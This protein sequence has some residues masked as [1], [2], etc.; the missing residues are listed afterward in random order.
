MHTY[1]KPQLRLTKPL[2]LTHMLE[3]KPA[4]PEVPASPQVALIASKQLS[5]H[6]S[7]DGQLAG[8]LVQSP[9]SLVLV[10]QNRPVAHSKLLQD[11]PSATPEPASAAVPPL[12]AVA[13]STA[14]MERKSR[15]PM[16]RVV[17]DEDPFARI[18]PLGIRRSALPAG[19]GV[20]TRS[21]APCHGF[22]TMSAI[23][24]AWSAWMIS[25]AVS[26]LRPGLLVAQSATCKAAMPVAIDTRI[27]VSSSD[28]FVKCTSKKPAT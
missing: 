27:Q 17:I 10:K 25:L 3:P 9:L 16:F 13:R 20:D 22:H 7:D 5:P 19:A 28:R 18:V 14:G 15:S 23:V 24:A 12:H 6:L 26:D 1:C 21:H 11:A 2:M 8:I 4:S